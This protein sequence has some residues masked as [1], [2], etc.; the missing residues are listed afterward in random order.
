MSSLGYVEEGEKCSQ[1]KGLGEG[2][3]VAQRT[4]TQASQ[5]AIDGTCH[6]QLHEGME[7][8]PERL[9]D[10]R[11]SCH[12]EKNRQWNPMPLPPYML[13]TEGSIIEEKTC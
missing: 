1:V 11:C 7:A 13:T 9:G 12:R 4:K 6:E 2:E 8:V 10:S 5:L 3:N